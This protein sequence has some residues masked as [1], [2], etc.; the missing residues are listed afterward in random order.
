MEF[1][2]KNVDRFKDLFQ[3]NPNA[4]GEHIP[5]PNPVEGQKSKGKSFTKSATVL[6]DHYLKHLHGEISLGIVPL[7]PENTVWFM[8]IDIDI[9]PLDP[10]KYINIIKRAGLPLMLFKSKSGGI[11]L[12]LF[13]AEPVEA[14]KALPHVQLIVQI[15]GLPEDTEIF[16]KQ[17]RLAPGAVGNWINLPYYKQ[18]DTRRY[19]YDSNGEPLALEN[20]IDLAHASRITLTGLKLIMDSLPMALGPPCLQTIYLNGG[21]DKGERNEY[22]S[23]CAVYLKDRFKEDFG[24]NLHALNSSMD[25]PI[26]YERLDTTVIASHTK[27]DYFYRCKNSILTPFCNKA[28]CRERPH[29]ISSSG[30][31][32][33]NFEGLVQVKGEDPY[34]KWTVNDV[35]MTFYDSAEILNQAKFRQMCFAQLYIYPQKMTDTAWGEV[36]NRA[37][38]NIT[39]EDVEDENDMSSSSLWMSKVSEFLSRQECATPRQVEDGLVWGEAKTGFLYFKADKMLSFLIESRCFLEYKPA[40]HKK[41][42]KELGADPKSKLSIGSSVSTRAWSLNIIKKHKEGVLLNVPAPEKVNGTT[43]ARMDDTGSDQFAKVNFVD[44]EKF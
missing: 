42:L 1:V 34:Y 39:I 44:E 36:I 2:S 33:L 29:G 14:S 37:L 13:F 15:L 41:M 19:A 9:Y 31:S 22:L 35:E 5:E 3:G 4:Y 6:F 25:H 27:K 38:S 20:M 28:I 10:Q 30:M 12:Y 18:K 24:T 8:V 43:I 17:V 16:P 23:N 40:K 7:T 21:P 11:H 26:S 32:G